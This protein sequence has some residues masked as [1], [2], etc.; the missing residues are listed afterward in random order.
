MR[1]ALAIVGVCVVGRVAV[2]GGDSSWDGTYGK[3]AQGGTEL[4]PDASTAVV[5]SAGQF[6]IVWNIKEGDR[7]VRVGRI[8]GTVGAT[9]AVTTK[10]ALIEPFPAAAK[11][12][13]ENMG[14][15]LDNLQT[16]AREMKIAFRESTE[17]TI[18]LASGL[19]YARW[20]AP[21]TRPKPTAT[22]EK[23]ATPAASDSAPAKKAAKSRAGSNSSSS[24]TA[25][26]SKSAPSTSKAASP[27]KPSSPSTATASPSTSKPSPPP[28]K[29]SP[30]ASKPS[31]SASSEGSESGRSGSSRPSPPPKPAPPPPPP[32]KGLGN[33]ADCNYS[34]Q[35]VSDSCE[36]GKC[37]GKGSSKA[38]GNGLACTYSSDCA[39]GNCEYGKCA[40]RGSKK[41]LASGAPCT[42]SSDCHS[43]ECL[44]GKCE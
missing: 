31:T 10:A 4:C 18:D 7:L 13:L 38:I 44:Y 40:S 17:R 29:P 35:C 2:A 32:K 37:V 26:P 43:D 22:A 1:C 20:N 15:S 24:K 30:P 34:S 28:S 9:G 14:D 25:S 5:V 6:S 33:G 42:Y 3:D 8:D 36:F 27:S 16:I 23:P 19:C 11:Q 39:S 12:S 41:D 21:G